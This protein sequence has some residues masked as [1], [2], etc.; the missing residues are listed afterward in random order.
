MT[1]PSYQELLETNTEA[2]TLERKINMLAAEETGCF[3]AVDLLLDSKVRDIASKNQRI[4]ILL[5][6]ANIAKMEISQN[7]SNVLFKNRTADE[8]IRLYQ[9]MVLLLR[10]IEFDFPGE[11]L[12]EIVDYMLSEKISATAVFGIINGARIILQKDKVRNGIMKVLG[13]LG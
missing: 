1:I 7:E 8:L 3:E 4:F 9:N 2:E 12:T 5:I 10:R 11:F 13:D 6:M